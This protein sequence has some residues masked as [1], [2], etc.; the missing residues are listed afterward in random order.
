M[1]LNPI[2][3]TEK[4]VRDHLRFQ[5][6]AYPFADECLHGQLRA[7]LSFDETRRSPLFKGP[8]TSLSRVGERISPER[9]Y[10]L[11]GPVS[12]SNI[13]LTR[14]YIKTDPC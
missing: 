4:V 14:S 1:A 11:T 10:D 7:L 5:L 9:K 8:I 3:F 12:G 2:V 13:G 6:T